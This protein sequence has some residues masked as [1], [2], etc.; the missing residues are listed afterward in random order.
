[1][2]VLA[3]MQSNAVETGSGFSFPNYTLQIQRNLPMLVSHNI[4]RYNDELVNEGQEKRSKMICSEC[5]L[6]LCAEILH[7]TTSKS[8]ALL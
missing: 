4:I 7:H 2:N 3:N 8:I 5:K 1:M 6:P